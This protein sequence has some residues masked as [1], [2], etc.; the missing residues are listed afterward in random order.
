[1]NL[2][3]ARKQSNVKP[4]DDVDTANRTRTENHALDAKDREETN[5]ETPQ[6]IRAIETQEDLETM[7]AVT[8]TTHQKI[9]AEVEGVAAA[10]GRDSGCL[11]HRFSD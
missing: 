6:P 8:K 2:G 11:M 10:A 9:Q 4:I 1:M 7:I 5:R 3:K